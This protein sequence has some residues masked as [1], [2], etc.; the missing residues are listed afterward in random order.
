M[1]TKLLNQDWKVSSHYNEEA[2]QDKFNKAGD[3]DLLY[4][5]GHG[6]SNGSLALQKY[7]KQNKPEGSYAN[8]DD[9]WRFAN[10]EYNE[11]DWAITGHKKMRMITFGY[12]M[13]RLLTLLEL[14]T[15]TIG[16]MEVGTI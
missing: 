15:S 3:D 16:I 13:E 12:K 7:K 9:A 6:S 4:F 11:F 14:K 5:T 10:V 2:T 8:W 1:A